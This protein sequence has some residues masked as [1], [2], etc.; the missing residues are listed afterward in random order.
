LWNAQCTIAVMS[1]VRPP[2]TVFEAL[3]ARVLR[4]AGVSSPAERQAAA[5]A[6]GGGPYLEKVRAHAYK[7]TDEDIA[8]L[9][10]AGMDE[11]TIF[12]LTI[13]AAVGV[14]ERRLARA[15]EVIDAAE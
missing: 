8:A 10:A 15:M 9:K 11:E 7:I 2:G 12:E 3:V 1:K 4:G 14:A 5:K 6:T 13:A